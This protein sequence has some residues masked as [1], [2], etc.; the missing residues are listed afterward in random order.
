MRFSRLPGKAFVILRAGPGIIGF[1][2]RLRPFVGFLRFGNLVPH[3][4]ISGAIIASAEGRRDQDKVNKER[5]SHK[6]RP[7][8]RPN[9]TKARNLA[10]TYRLPA[11]KAGR[12]TTAFPE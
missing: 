9:A 3:L 5:T 10:I 12:R 7:K 8:Y 4:I 6:I 11:D 2:E 1:L